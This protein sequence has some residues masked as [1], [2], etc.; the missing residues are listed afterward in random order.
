M[1]EWVRSGEGTESD[2]S[3]F[4]PQHAIHLGGFCF[5]TLVGAGL[6]GLAA[7]AALLDYMNAYVA[8][9]AAAS[10]MPMRGIFLA[11]HPWALIRVAAYLLLGVYLTALSLRL[12]RRTQPLPPHSWLVTGFGLTVLDVLMKGLLAPGWRDLLVDF[13]AQ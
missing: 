5:A 6:P 12:W 11:W 10:S 1:M 9:Y 13:L 7:G 2:P 4:L 3:R 8:S